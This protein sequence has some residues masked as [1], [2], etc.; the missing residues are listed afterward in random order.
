MK[1]QIRSVKVRGAA[2]EVWEMG[3]GPPVIILTG[4]NSPIWEWHAVV[5]AL[6]VQYRVILFHRPGLGK[7][8]LGEAIRRTGALTEELAELL[9]LLSV[10]EPVVLIGHSYGGLCA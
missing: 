2:M 4:M 1:E 6:S 8:E 5:Y 9:P 10:H 3:E 7:S